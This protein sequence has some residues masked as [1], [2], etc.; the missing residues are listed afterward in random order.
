M[1]C[2]LLRAG[3]MA[4]SEYDPCWSG[5]DCMGKRCAWWSPDKGCCSMVVISQELTN[6]QLKMKLS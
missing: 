5:D 3:N 6:I 4:D 1:K 2:P